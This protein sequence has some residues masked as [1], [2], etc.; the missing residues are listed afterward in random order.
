MNGVARNMVG[1]R[2]RYADLIAE[3]EPRFPTADPE[4][5]KSVERPALQD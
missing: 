1:K 2:L 4:L 3:V 5:L